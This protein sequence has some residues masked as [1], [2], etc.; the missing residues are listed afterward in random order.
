MLLFLVLVQPFL[1]YQVHV[2]LSPLSSCRPGR[3]VASLM[4]AGGTDPA[5]AD[6]GFIVRPLLWDELVP[7]LRP[8]EVEEVSRMLGKAT[9]D[10]NEVCGGRTYCSP[11]LP[12]C[13]LAGFVLF[14][15]VHMA[16]LFVQASLVN[17]WLEMSDR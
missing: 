2:L 11:P 3:G 5:M 6:D 10:K 1:T 15:L 7:L 12:L 13:F 14:W 8:P 9:I 17:L 16:G 4:D